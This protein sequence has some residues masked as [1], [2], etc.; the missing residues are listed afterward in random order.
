MLQTVTSHYLDCVA[1]CELS[2]SGLCCRL[3]ALIFRIVLQIVSFHYSDFV[4][5][6]LTSHNPD[7]VADSELP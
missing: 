1:D 6:T 3:R 4:L 2:L 7:L 5:Q